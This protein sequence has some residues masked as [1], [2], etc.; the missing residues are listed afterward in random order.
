MPHVSLVMLTGGPMYMEQRP[1][2]GSWKGYLVHPEELILAPGS[3]TTGE[4][5]WK[6]LTS[7]LMQ[8]LH[9][10]LSKELL[11]RT[12]EEIAGLDPDRLTLA[13][14]TGF[15]DPLL[16]QI[17]LTLWR[18]LE[19]QEA[20]G[21]LYAQTAAQLLAVHLLRHYTSSP[22][23]IPELSQRLTHQQVKRVTDFILAHLAQDL[24]LDALARQTGF[25]SYHFARLF[26]HTLGESPHQFVLRQRIEKAQRL[27]QQ[28]EEP[29]VQVALE[30]GFA[31]Q[32]HLTRI[33]K[34][35]LGLTPRM[36]RQNWR[37][38]AHFYQNSQE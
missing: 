11:V 27:L 38:S 28:T 37:N 33:F 19:M 4:L 20:T 26:R 13:G 35:Q 18:E 22:L 17:S 30:S 9:L 8:T 24:S 1:A 16:T 14:R 5:R 2:N 29:L 32:S 23:T 21:R 7:A 3:S 10:H 12:A 31:N 15:Q 34:R 6:G 25:S 36:Y